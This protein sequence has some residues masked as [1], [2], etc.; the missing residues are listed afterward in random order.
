[1]VIQ[2]CCI[3]FPHSEIFGSKVATHLPGAYRSYAASFIAFLSQ[4]ILHTPLLLSLYWYKLT[5]KIKLLIIFFILF[6]L[7]DFYSIIKDA[8]DSRNGEREILFEKNIRFRGHNI[9]VKD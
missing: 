2:V 5:Q 9:R 8:V 7:F 4:G 1:M 3:G 6:L